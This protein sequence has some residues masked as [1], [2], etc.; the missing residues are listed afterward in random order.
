MRVCIYCDE[1]ITV[2]SIGDESWDYCEGCELVEGGTREIPEDGE[3]ND[4]GST[5]L[6]SDT[7]VREMDDLLT[8]VAEI[9]GIII[10]NETNKRGYRD[11]TRT[12]YNNN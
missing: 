9:Y 6:L 8:H 7:E 12:I 2:K 10:N 5:D 11:A 1:E 3:P 4:G